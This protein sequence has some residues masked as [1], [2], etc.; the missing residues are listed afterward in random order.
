M[1]AVS[2]A[3]QDFLEASKTYWNPNKTGFWQERASIW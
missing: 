2:Q 3:K 1:P